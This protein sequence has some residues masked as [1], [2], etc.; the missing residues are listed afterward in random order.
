LPAS[1]YALFLF[2]AV[3]G[4]ACDLVTKSYVFSRYYNLGRANAQLAQFPHWWVEGILGI[5]TSTNPG[6]LFGIGKGYSLLFAGFSLVA[7]VG[8]LVWLFYYRAAWDRWLTFALGLITGGIL[9]NFYDRIGLGYQSGYPEEVK[10]NV[11]DWIL[12][13]LEGVP[14]LDPWPN[15]N[16]AD[17]LLVTG[18][19]MLF[20]H[21]FLFAATPGPQS[22]DPTDS[23]FEQAH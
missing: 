14:M 1:R 17:S 13:R 19:I 18:A 2:P 10:N 22:G 5:Q 15:F 11:R 9:G 4:V 23:G 3:I 12:F 6:A 16:I 8:I 20:L 7:L 21:A